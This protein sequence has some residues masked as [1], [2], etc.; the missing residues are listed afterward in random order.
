[1]KDLY[2]I[3]VGNV[4][5]GLTHYGPFDDAEEANEYAKYK[6]DDEDWVVA[7]LYPLEMM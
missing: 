3:I 6:F 1:M 7:A 5:N 2:L 4:V